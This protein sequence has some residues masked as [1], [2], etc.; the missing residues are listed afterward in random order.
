MYVFLECMI[1]SD[2]MKIERYCLLETKG[3]G[4]IG[5]EGK[6][7]LI[8]ARV[9]REILKEID[10]FRRANRLSWTKLLTRLL[11]ALS[12]GVKREAEK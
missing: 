3:D 9:P 2:H 12:D 1:N 6:T 10:P 7:R 4:K 8:Q 11:R 5:Q